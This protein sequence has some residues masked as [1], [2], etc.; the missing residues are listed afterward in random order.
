MKPRRV[1]H[2]T[3]VLNYGGA[4][5]VDR[6]TRALDKKLFEPI[7]AFDTHEQS[8]IR[9]N[10]S[11]SKIKTIDLKKP[12]DHPDIADSKPHKSWNVSEFLE[13]YFNMRA[14]NAYLSLKNVRN[15]LFQQ[16]PRIKIF[17]KLIKDNRIDIVHTHSD[18]YHGK[19]ELCAARICGIPCILHAH[20]YSK[21]T[22]FEKFFDR[23]VDRFIF[24][25]NDVARYYFSHGISQDKGVVIHNGVEISEFTR[26]YKADGIR[27]QFNI[28]PD[29]ILIGLIGRIDWWKGHEYFFEAMA[30]ATNHIKGLRGIVVGEPNSD[31][32]NLQYFKKLQLLLNS[33]NLTEKII[34]TGFRNDVPQVINDIDV[35]VHASSQPEPFGLVVIE[36]MAAG[37]PLVATAAGGVLDIIQD[38]VNGLL[39]PCK[40]SKALAGAILQLATDEE[41]AKRLGQEA[42]RRINENF[43]L[44]RQVL[45]VQSL[46]DLALDCHPNKIEEFN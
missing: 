16:A 36:G 29:D 18:L 35:L 17:L 46:Y 23:F 7:I 39:V 45:A 2:V 3:R 21:F 28:K 34:F 32:I 5:V 22:P 40:D 33:L 19:P 27:S 37:K 41:M 42:S 20:G 38:G 14:R 4:T 30:D 10:L 31:N 12:I 26:S 25:S 1:L 44:K 9:K 13:S 8:N 24:I 15:F 11:N 43:S 6:L